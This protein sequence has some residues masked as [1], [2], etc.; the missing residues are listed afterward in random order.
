MALLLVVWL[1]SVQTICEFRTTYSQIYKIKI[2]LR[3]LLHKTSLRHVASHKGIFGNKSADLLSKE[4]TAKNSVDTSH[5]A[6]TS[7]IKSF[8][9]ICLMQQWS[10][11]RDYSENT[12]DIASRVSPNPLT[13]TSSTTS[14]LTGATN[15]SLAST[16]LKGSASS[17]SRKVVSRS[18]TSLHLV[19]GWTIYSSAQL[20]L[21]K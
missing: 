15:S 19:V 11:Q 8:L 20:Y 7:Y 21:K 3:N 16:C 2:Q 6:P 5:R 9:K 1:C 17:E 18:G 13:L 12:Y 14:F 4:A 10:D